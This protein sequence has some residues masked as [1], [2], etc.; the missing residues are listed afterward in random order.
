[1][2]AWKIILSFLLPLTALVIVPW[3]VHTWL[4]HLIFSGIFSTLLG[5]LFMLTGF[6]FLAWTNVLFIV[7]GQGTLAPWDATKQLVITGPY[8]HVRNPMIMGVVAIL[9]GEAMVF[10]SL[11]LFAW[12]LLFAA[13]NHLWFVLWEEPELEQKFG[14]AYVEYK[15]NVPRWVPKSQPFQLH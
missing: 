15:A 6:I 11:Y 8:R 10:G 2:P 4:E 7:L 14:R 5:A 3:A 9:L 13:I 1:M 12:A